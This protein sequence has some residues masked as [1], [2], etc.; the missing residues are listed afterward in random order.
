MFILS[1]VLG[2]CILTRYVGIANLLTILLVILVIGKGSTKKKLFDIA[3]I[4]GVSITPVVL[5]TYRNY[6]LTQTINNRNVGFYPPVQK[7]FINAFHTFFT[8]YLPE[9]AVIG[10]EKFYFYLLVGLILGMF[11]AVLTYSFRKHARPFY[12]LRSIKNVHPLNLVY[13]CYAFIYTGVVFFSKT[14]I[15]PGT[16]MSDR[17]F[18]PVLLASIL[19]L[20]NW[21]A[22]VWRSD[23]KIGRL[24]VF[25]LSVYLFLLFFSSSVVAVPK[26]HENGLGLGKKSLQNSEAMHLLSELAK[27]NKIYSNDPFAIYFYTEQRGYRRSLFSPDSIQDGEVVIAIFGA[28]EGDAFYEKYAEYLEM[29]QSDQVVSV[30]GFRSE[31]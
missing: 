3:I 1:I 17:I 22:F 19:L 25:L 11:I 23:H 5:W 31:R 6:A 4:A 27:D 28:S 16:G 30:Y 13:I 18:S 12:M 29:I 2:L 20:V 10:F 14:F 7:N 15:D 9:E 8:W 21:L 26:F 24:L